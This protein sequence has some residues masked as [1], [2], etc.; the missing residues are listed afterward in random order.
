MCT[1]NSTEHVATRVTKILP[2]SW[3]DDLKLVSDEELAKRYAELRN[4]EADN[5]DLEAADE[6]NMMEGEIQHRWLIEQG[7]DLSTL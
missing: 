2:Q 7:V 3:H 1:D 4:A 5:N 6:A